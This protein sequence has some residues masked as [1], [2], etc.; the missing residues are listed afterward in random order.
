M[1]NTFLILGLLIIISSC[2]TPSKKVENET[3]NEAINIEQLEQELYKVKTED[4]DSVWR[5]SD[6]DSAVAVIL[7]G[8]PSIESDVKKMD[9]VYAKSSRTRL[10]PSQLKSLTES[11]SGEKQG[12]Y[13]P[14]DCFQ[15]FHGIFFYKKGEITGRIAIC[16]SC[17]YYVTL[18]RISGRIDLEKTNQMFLDLGLPAYNWAN[19]EE[20]ANS[21]VKYGDF[22]KKKKK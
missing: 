3:V 5:V 12:T 1:K 4:I 18:P 9:T 11:L 15:P 14:A 7:N 17:G 6:F 8:Y 13:S 22:F 2:S 16:F 21:K 10:S 20:T 19:P